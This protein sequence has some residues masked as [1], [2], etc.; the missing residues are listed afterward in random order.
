MPFFVLRPR[1]SGNSQNARL[2][3]E[4]REHSDRLRRQVGHRGS[5][6]A[7]MGHPNLDY[8]SCLKGSN[9]PKTWEDQV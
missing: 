7:L 3:A 1:C 9:L 5:I 4:V 2:V 6:P 8:I